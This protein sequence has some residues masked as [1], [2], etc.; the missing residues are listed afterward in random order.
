M[1]EEQEKETKATSIDLDTFMS[2]PEAEDSKYRQYS[3]EEYLAALS[4][5]VARNAATIAENLEVTPYTVERRLKKMTGE[6]LVKYDG[7]EAFYVAK[8][9]KK[10]SKKKAKKEVEL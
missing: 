6:Y 9:V 7:P 1:S 3:D 5:K 10:G 2:L 8:P 4:T